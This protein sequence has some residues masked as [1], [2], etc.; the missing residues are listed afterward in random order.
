MF[1]LPKSCRKLY[2]FSCDS[3]STEI[4]VTSWC[5][6]GKQLGSSLKTGNWAKHYPLADLEGA[7]GG[8]RPLNFLEILILKY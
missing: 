4:K 6:S 7:V 8:M 2:S 1:L 3:T 5:F